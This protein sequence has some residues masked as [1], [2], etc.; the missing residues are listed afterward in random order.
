M[1][2]LPAN[3]VRVIR[4]GGIDGDDGG[5]SMCRSRRG[6]RSRSRSR[7]RRR[8]R[9]TVW[10]AVKHLLVQAAKLLVLVMTWKL[11]SGNLEWFVVVVVVVVVRGR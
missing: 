10:F 5:M 8:R 1:P 6:R 9:T 4:S 3:L 11:R 2:L 7:R